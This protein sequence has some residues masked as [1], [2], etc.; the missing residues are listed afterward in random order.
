MEG[1]RSR[2]VMPADAILRVD[3]ACHGIER[4]MNNDVPSRSAA[5]RKRL[6][7]GVPCLG[8]CGALGAPATLAAES[9]AANA[10]PANVYADLNYDWKDERG[11]SARLSDW[12]GKTTLL[13]M[14]YPTCRRTCTYTL[15]RLEELQESADHAGTPIEVVVVSYDPD[16]QPKADRVP[17]PPRYRPRELALPD[18]ERRHHAAVRQSAAI[19]ILDDGRSRGPRLQDPDDRCGRPCRENPDLGIPQ[20]GSFRGGR[21]LPAGG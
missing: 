7:L 6:M 21:D 11:A 9:I 15:H 16:A 17:A 10:I 19:S 1:R 14:A 5:I 3:H 2:C 4:T 12:S 20:R 13:T 8:L 18:R